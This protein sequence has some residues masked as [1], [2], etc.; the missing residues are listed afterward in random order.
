MVSTKLS[1]TCFNDANCAL[2]YTIWKLTCL[3]D[4]TIVCTVGT[5]QSLNSDGRLYRLKGKTLPEKCRNKTGVLWDMLSHPPLQLVAFYTARLFT[6]APAQLKTIGKHSFWT[7]MELPGEERKAKGKAKIF[8]KWSLSVFI[9]HK[10]QLPNRAFL[11]QLWM[12][13][14]PAS[15]STLTGRL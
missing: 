3:C 10:S 2:K 12:H 4:L 15:L 13:K 11:Q 9:H 14:S 1:E 7:D 6:I 5:L 8:P